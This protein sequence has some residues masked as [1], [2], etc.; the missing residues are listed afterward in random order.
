MLKQ[1][2]KNIFLLGAFLFFFLPLSGQAAEIEF[3]SPGLPS[4]VSVSVVEDKAGLP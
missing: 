3:K 1:R 2:F 4:G